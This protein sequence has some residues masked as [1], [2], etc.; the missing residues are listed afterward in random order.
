MRYYATAISAFDKNRLQHFGIKGQRWGIRRFQNEDGTLTDAG[1]KRYGSSLD[2]VKSNMEKAQKKETELRRRSDDLNSRTGFKAVFTTNDF[3]NARARKKA[4]KAGKEAAEIESVY[5]NLKK[6]DEEQARKRF[7]GDEKLN[8]LSKRM[9]SFDKATPDE[10]LKI[11]DEV[12]RMQT[13]IGEEQGYGSPAFEDMN[14]WFWD[15]RSKAGEAKFKELDSLPKGQKRDYALTKLLGDSDREGQDS[16]YVDALIDR[17]QERHG[18]YLSGNF[19]SE[20]SKKLIN[21]FGEATDKADETRKKF[22][23]EDQKRGIYPKDY[24]GSTGFLHREKLAADHPEVKQTMD[25]QESKWKEYCAQVLKDMDLPV[26]EKTI[27][28]IQHVIIWN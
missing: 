25:A 5:E 20:A 23:Q 9:D 7:E 3:K 2:E 22:Y 21:E 8:S 26:N 4:A 27:E 16:I 14:D 12:D 18:D 15:H 28:Y 6:H 10:K 17:M 19:K 11:I 24:S 13:K 1:K